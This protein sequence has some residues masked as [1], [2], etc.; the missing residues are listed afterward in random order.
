MCSDVTGKHHHSHSVN[1]KETSDSD[2]QPDKK[3]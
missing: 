2:F 1:N 3:R